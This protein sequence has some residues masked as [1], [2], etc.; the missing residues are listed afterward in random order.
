MFDF[1]LD[2][3]SYFDFNTDKN[4][5]FVIKQNTDLPILEIKPI[6]TANYFQFLELLQNCS[7]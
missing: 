4:R 6:R 5:D 3:A 1:E 2:N 7:T